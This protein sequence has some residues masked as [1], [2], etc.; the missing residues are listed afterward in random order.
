MGLHANTRANL[1]PVY[2][3]LPLIPAHSASKTRVNALMAGIQWARA[4]RG[5]GSP[6]RGPP[7]QAAA[8]GPPR[9]GGGGGAGGAPRRARARPAPLGG[10]SPRARADTL[11]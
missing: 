2:A 10:S 8:G 11:P 6:H 1:V 4:V 9:G 3:P 7:T 5:L